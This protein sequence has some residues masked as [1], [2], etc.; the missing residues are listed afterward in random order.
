MCTRIDHMTSIKCHWHHCSVPE[1]YM[2][3]QTSI[4]HRICIQVTAS[5]LAHPIKTIKAS[6]FLEKKDDRFDI[7]HNLFQHKYISTPTATKEDQWMKAAQELEQALRMNLPT[8]VPTMYYE[9]FERV[10][11]IFNEIA[12]QKILEKMYKEPVVL[13]YSNWGQVQGCCSWQQVQVCS[14]WKNVWGWKNP[15]ACWWMS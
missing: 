13:G 5:T 14:R 9:D 4:S 3:S 2:T 11:I 10:S 7:W 6:E 12:S 1:K 15:L 8:V